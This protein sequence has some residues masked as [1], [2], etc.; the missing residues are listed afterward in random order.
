MKWRQFLTPVQSMETEKAKA[1]MADHREGTFTLLDVR[2]PGEYEKDRIPG[3]KLI[4]LPELTNR[5]EELDQGKPVI[6]Y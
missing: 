5:F 2:Q 3:A 1:F 6:V 4:P